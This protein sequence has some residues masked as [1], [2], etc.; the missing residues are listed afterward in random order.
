MD[1]AE[2]SAIAISRRVSRSFAFFDLCGFTD[3]LDVAGDE[4]AV[5][6][7]QELR[8]VVRE[9]TPLFGVRVEKWL[10]DGVMLVGVE[11]DALVGA[12][13]AIKSRHD[14]VGQLP[15]RGGIATGAVLLLEGDDYVGRDV[16]LASRLCDL[17]Q[18]GELLAATD[19]LKLP[20]WALASDRPAA[21]VAGMASPVA[22]VALEPDRH[23]L[24]K[25][26]RGRSATA[27]LAVVEGFARGLW[28][29]PAADQSSA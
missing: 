25:R 14:R 18:P 22:V 5:A 9:V 2:L 3:F 28:R 16:N 27:L 8:S 4:A 24:R 19:G 6:E 15:L 10:G 23:V 1:T 26:S 17:A 12:A 7:L 20:E 11:P 29:E 21:V 13:L